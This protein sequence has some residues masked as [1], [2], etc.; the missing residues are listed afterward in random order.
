M[1]SIKKTIM[2]RDGITAEEANTRIAEAKKALEQY[3]AEG[4]IFESE[5]V[6]YE[7]FG[8]EPD[9]LFELI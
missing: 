1:L 7:Y 9:Y 6:C 5:E 8:L 4:L 2:H 3:L